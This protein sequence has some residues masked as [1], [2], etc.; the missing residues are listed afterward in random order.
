MAQGRPRKVAIVRA[1]TEN[2]A[3]EIFLIGAENLAPQKHR[4]VT[5]SPASKPSLATFA[6]M[7]NSCPPP[8]RAQARLAPTM[9]VAPPDSAFDA[10]PIVPLERA[11]SL[12]E[13][14]LLRESVSGESSV[15]EQSSL[16]E[17]SP[18]SPM[19]VELPAS[20]L[21]S[22]KAR[23]RDRVFEVLRMLVVG[24]WASGV[25]V[26]VLALSVR[27]IH[28]D[29]TL[30]RFIALVV[31][32]LALFFGCRSFAFRAKGGSITRQAKLFI[33]AELLGFPLNLLVFHL[34]S[35]YAPIVP[36]EFASQAANF[37]V[38]VAFAY[39]VRQLLVFQGCAEKGCAER[40]RASV[41]SLPAPAATPESA[42]TSS[43]TPA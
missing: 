26:A 27:W 12:A 23:R 11:T 32:G 9:V 2:S 38:F 39:P 19:L 36:P 20:M 33:V 30:S 14:P 5:N 28:L 4:F 43:P 29:P 25:D 13:E 40:P 35:A 37:L 10:H 42:R 31:S 1:D 22:R 7:G 3:A 17:P 34:L 16:T 15:L 18:T 21:P 6:L 8:R 41:A 24:L